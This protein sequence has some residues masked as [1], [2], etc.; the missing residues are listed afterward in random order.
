MR[1]LRGTL[2][3][4]P[5]F[6][7]LSAELIERVV[8]RSTMRR[9]ERGA[10]IIAQGEAGRS[11]H[12][13][14]EG[15]ARVVLRHGADSTTLATVGR[16]AVIGEMALLTGEPATADVVAE[17]DVHAVALPIE[18]FRDLVAEHPDLTLV[19]T[20]LVAE[21]LGSSRGDGLAGKVLAGYRIGRPLGRGGMSIVYEAEEIATGVRVALKMMS[22]RLAHRDD[23]I[24][25]FAREGEV[26]RALG[27]PGVA[28]LHGTFSAFGT[29]FLVL[30]F[31]EG[32][33]LDRRL[34]RDGAL[35]LREALRLLE[36]IADAMAH[37]HA[38]GLVHRDVKPGNVM[39]ASSGSVKLLDFGL[40]GTG[41][42]HV[43]AGTP[44]SMP[45]EQI[46]GVDSGP[47]TDVYAL[48]CLA[49]EMFS[50]RSP[51]SGRTVDRLLDEK[52]GYVLPSANEIAP[53]LPAKVHAFLAAAL[54]PDPAR[55]PEVRAS[56]FRRSAFR[57]GN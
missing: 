37:I 29:H 39:L 50:G 23:A 16:G 44:L 1:E 57:W 52:R 11:L 42:E 38:R 22:H 13:V 5:P 41:A 30:E 4:S 32:E 2:Q 15:E 40:A 7:S 55:R 9:F 3:A 45:P 36:R 43:L 31:V 35:P 26:L 46:D 34:E 28:R 8:E 17:T 6:Q 20:H 14:A 12:V 54:D 33:S 51:F 21:R 47:A 56:T 25:R 18:A 10:A 48:G 27:H 19:L 49:F 53:R 24:A